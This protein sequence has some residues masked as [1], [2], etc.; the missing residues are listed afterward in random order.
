MTSLPDILDTP[1]NRALKPGT[2]YNKWENV[3][4]VAQLIKLW[5]TGESRPDNR[6]FVTFDKANKKV[7]FAKYV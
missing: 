3:E 4:Q 2:D 1:E 6:A 5:C 7:M